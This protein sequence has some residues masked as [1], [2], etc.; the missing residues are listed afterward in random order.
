LVSAVNRSRQ[1]ENLKVLKRETPGFSPGSSHNVFNDARQ[2]A[3]IDN[4]VYFVD[5]P[6]KALAF[7]Y[8]P[9]RKDVEWLYMLIFGYILNAKAYTVIT[10]SGIRYF[11]MFIDIEKE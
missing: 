5:K 8:P 3:G 7:K 11:I 1:T 9:N 10:N 6:E 4:L 2:Y